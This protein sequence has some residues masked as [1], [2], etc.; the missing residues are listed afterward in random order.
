MENGFLQN[1]V[2]SVK[3]VDKFRSGFSKESDGR[4]L[5]TGCKQVYQ[6]PT[7][8]YD[9]LI[10]ILSE[11]EQRWFESQMGLDK[12]N[13]AFNNKEKSFWRDFRVT[14][15]KKGRTLNL[16]DLEDNL[17]YRVLKASNGIANSKDMINVLQ[18]SF[19]LVTEEE[20]VDAS[21][22]LADRYE[23]ASKLFNTVSKSDK[24]MINVLRLLG[25]K[26][27]AESGTKWL[28][29]EIV[30]VIDQKAKI[31]GISS[32]D[33]FISIA[34][35]PDFEVKVFIM[36]AMEIGE[37]VVDGTTYKL[38]SGDIIGY[39][40][41]QAITYFNNPKNQQVKLLV[42]DRVKNNK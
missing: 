11:E 25:K 3:I 1:K 42:E 33:D 24:K 31:S 34:S 8:Q 36:D 5:Y 2:V 10:P 22:K 23:Q 27:P 13:L 20:E 6:A 37:I 38:R 4:T 39:D 35:D 21:I 41:S 19:Y 15:D 29:S 26:V 12:G 14:L 16:M 28:K 32:M 17:A 30:K 18:H 7:N 9:R 40:Y